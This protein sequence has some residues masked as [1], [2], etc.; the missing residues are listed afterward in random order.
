[1]S[2][3]QRPARGDRRTA[4]ESAVPAVPDDLA[5][6]LATCRPFDSLST[7]DLATAVVVSARSGE[8]EIPAAV[9]QEIDLERAKAQQDL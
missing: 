8:V 7:G 9:M 3:S 6:L 5:A 1:M 4:D 2:D